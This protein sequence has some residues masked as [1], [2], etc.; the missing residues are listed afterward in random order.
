MAGHSGALPWMVVRSGLKV[1]SKSSTCAAMPL[2]NAARLAEVRS[3]RADERRRARPVGVER[4]DSRSHPGALGGGGPADGAAQP[5]DEAADRLL[6]H[7]GRA[8]R[9]SARPM[10]TSARAALRSPGNH[11]QATPVCQ[12]ERNSVIQT[13]WELTCSTYDDRTSVE[14]RTLLDFVTH[15]AATDVPEDVLHESTRCLLDHLGLAVAGAQEPAARIASEQCEL[16]GGQ[17]A[18][19][20]RSARPTGCA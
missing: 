4:A 17:R 9:L 15:T 6:H 3:G 19:H 20:E 14:T 7:V 18:G 16:M 8:D 11:D 5:V 12:T 13:T 2:A 10:R 1:S